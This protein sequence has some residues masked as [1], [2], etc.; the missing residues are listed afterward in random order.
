MGGFGVTKKAVDAA[1]GQVD[2]ERAAAASRV[3]ARD[4]VVGL[5]V[6]VGFKS[7]GSRPASPATAPTKLCWYHGRV[8]SIPPAFG[9]NERYGVMFD[10]GELH[11]DVKLGELRYAGPPR[12]AWRA[13]DVCWQ[14]S[15]HRA[16][17]K[18][19]GDGER[20]FDVRWRSR[21]KLLSSV[22]TEAEGKFVDG[23]A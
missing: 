12:R 17:A 16:E 5:E 2:A 15:W 11:E 18:P 13:A 4:A 22:H 10:D 19:S 3:S 6:L 7:G 8:V 14:G 20:T 21:G 1:T 9:S 23:A